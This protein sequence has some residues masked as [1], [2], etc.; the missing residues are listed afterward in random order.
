MI[1]A[2]LGERQ[3][4]QAAAEAGHEIDGLRGHKLGGQRQIAFV[5]PVFVIDHHHMRRRESRSG[6]R[7]ISE[8]GS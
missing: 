3:A 1:G 5:L 8:R 6:L 4:D 2:L 7:G